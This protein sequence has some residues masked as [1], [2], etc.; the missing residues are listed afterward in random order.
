MSAPRQFSIAHAFSPLL[1]LLFAAFFVAVFVSDAEGQTSV[2]DDGTRVSITTISAKKIQGRVKSVDTD[3]LH[4]YSGEHGGLLTVANSDI[5]II[6]VSR[7]RS[8]W[9]GAMRGA[10]W[11]AAV[12]VGIAAVLIPFADDKDGE[13]NVNELRAAAAMQ[14]VIGGAIWGAGIGAFVK[15]ER[16]ERVSPQ[17]SPTSSSSS[18]NLGF[19]LTSN[20]LH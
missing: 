6:R 14:L 1:R 12:G 16:W 18:V 7:G 4:L 2:L 20:V 19:R 5:T 15:K 10:A 11:G 3:S 17:R 8:A 13:V 9:A